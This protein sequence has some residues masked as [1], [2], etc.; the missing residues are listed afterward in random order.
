MKITHAHGQLSNSSTVPLKIGGKRVIISRALHMFHKAVGEKH[1][2]ILVAY[3]NCT[4]VSTTKKGLLRHRPEN[5]S[6]LC[7]LA[8]TLTGETHTF[9]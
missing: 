6:S 3:L 1:M 7:A 4:H 9:V 2:L 5:H 8:N